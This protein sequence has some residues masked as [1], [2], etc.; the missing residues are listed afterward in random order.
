[1]NTR[2]N[3]GRLPTIDEALGSCCIS[4]WLKDA[5]RSALQRDCVDAARDAE[6]LSKLL[7]THCDKALGRQVAL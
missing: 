4:Y 6:L 2:K 7:S 5:L 3:S 1:M